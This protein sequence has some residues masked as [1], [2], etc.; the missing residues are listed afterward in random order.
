MVLAR[1]DD[2]FL[3]DERIAMALGLVY[4]AVVILAGNGS[5]M[6]SSLSS[7]SLMGKSFDGKELVGDTIFGI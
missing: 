2:P 1:V 5:M 7:L 6:S 4:C 3:V